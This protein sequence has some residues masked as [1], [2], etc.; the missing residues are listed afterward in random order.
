MTSESGGAS[1]TITFSNESGE[2]IQLWWINLEGNLV[3]YGINQRGETTEIL[4]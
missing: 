1:I 3:D 4:T 2:S